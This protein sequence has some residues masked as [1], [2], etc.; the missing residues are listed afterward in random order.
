M[1]NATSPSPYEG[2]DD[3]VLAALID[4]LANEH[5]PAVITKPEQLTDGGRL[6]LAFKAGAHSVIDRLRREHTR[7]KEAG[8]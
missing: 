8:R 5:P 4:Q 3:D 2:F 6:E 1:D 7:R